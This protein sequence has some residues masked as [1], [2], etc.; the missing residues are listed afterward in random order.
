M[1]TQFYTQ[2]ESNPRVLSPSFHLHQNSRFRR[3]CWFRLLF[4][5]SSPKRLSPQLISS[6]NLSLAPHN[7]Y[8]MK[9]RGW[10]EEGYANSP[11]APLSSFQGA[12]HS[13]L[14]EC[15]G[16]TFYR[17]TNQISGFVTHYG[18]QR[19]KDMSS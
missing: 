15:E 3:T 14:D 7:K 16:V 10:H 11:C 13:G 12:Y 6:V 17:E 8:E 1:M 9:R 19:E 4:S 18:H 5:S 2:P